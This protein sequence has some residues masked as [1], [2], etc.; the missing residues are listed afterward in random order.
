MAR[1]M[2]LR[3]LSLVLAGAVAGCASAPRATGPQPPTAAAKATAAPTAPR[4]RATRSFSGTVQ[5]SCSQDQEIAAD[6]RSAIERAALSFAE[7]LTSDPADLLGRMTSEAQS[8]TTSQVMRRMAAELRQCR[9]REFKIERTYLVEATG[10][11]PDG[12]AICGLLANNQWVSVSVKTGTRQAHVILKAQALNKDYALALWLLPEDGAWKVGLA[13][14]N[15]A[16][17]SGRDA[18]QVFALAKAERGAGH[19]FNATLLYVV[20][21]GLVE[22][23]PG[24]QLGMTQSIAEDAQTFKVPA[25]LAGPPPFRWHLGDTTYTVASISPIGLEGQLGLILL[26]PQDTWP[27]TERVIES[28][29]KFITAFLAAHPEISTVFQFVAA[30]AE[31]PDHTGG[32]GTVYRIGKGFDP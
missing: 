3:S 24:M 29:K 20:A 6:E 1:A 11:A 26:L 9:A 32:Y 25:E 30:R 28:N 31:L 14:L 19:A 16:S 27:G 15:E 22:R 12:R 23:G 18:D 13:H 5:T 2:G 7:A 8:S 21:R 10:S 4:A 17:I